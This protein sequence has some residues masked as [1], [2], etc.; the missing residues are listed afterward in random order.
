VVDPAIVA[1]LLRRPRSPGPLDALTP[2]EA[3]VLGLMAEGR[4]N[5]AIAA[6]LDMGIKTVEAH[7]RQILRKLDLEESDQDHRRVLAVLSYLRSAP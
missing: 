1:R 7:I 5:A 3:E 2:R 4:S 6:A